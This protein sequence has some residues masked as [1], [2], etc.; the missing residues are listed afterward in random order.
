MLDASGKK[1]SGVS[2]ASFSET[3]PN[4]AS[5]ASYSKT[6]G[7]LP[8]VGQSQ[9]A[10][11]YAPQHMWQQGPPQPS[12]LSQQHNMQQ[13]ARPPQQSPHPQQSPMHAS[14][15]LHHAQSSSSMHG[16]PVQQ[17]QTMG[18]MG[19]ANYQGMGQNP[20]QPSPS[21]HQFMQHQSG[22]TQQPGMPGWAPNQTPQ[23]GW[24]SY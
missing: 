20:Y 23:S 14:P 9:G 10:H 21:P 18:A 8:S 19:D 12:P 4:S 7:M 1:T 2:G 6:S 16:T 5:R 24:Q 17:Y 15:Q 3:G 22:A 11:G 13:Y